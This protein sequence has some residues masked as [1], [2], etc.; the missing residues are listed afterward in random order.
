LTIRFLFL[1]LFPVVVLAQD[2]TTSPAKLVFVAGKTYTVSLQFNNCTNG[3]TTPPHD[4]TATNTK[5]SATGNGITVSTPAGPAHKCDWTGS[6]TLSQD[7]DT[8]VFAIVIQEEDKLTSIPFE[9]IAKAAGPIPPGLQPTVDVA[10]SVVP[11][12]IASDNFGGRITKLYY[13]IQVV[14]GNNSGYDLQLASI[15]FDLGSVLPDLNVPTDSYYMVRSS[16]QREQLVGVRNT[17]VNVIKAIGPILTGAAVFYTGTSLAGLHHKTHFLGITDI[18][19]NPFEKGV[20]AVF[21]DMTVQQ[22]INLDN[23]TLRDGLIIANNTQIRSIVFVNKDLLMQA[24]RSARKLGSSSKTVPKSGNSARPTPVDT[25][26]QIALINLDLAR[27]MEAIDKAEAASI[28]AAKHKEVEDKAAAKALADAAQVQG[29]ILLATTAAAAAETAAASKASTDKRA[30]VDAAAVQRKAV[31]DHASANQEQAAADA[32]AD[33]NLANQNAAIANRGDVETAQLVK[34]LGGENKI[35]KHEYNPQEVMR[36][37]GSLKLVGRSIQYLNRV[38]VISTPPGPGPQFTLSPASVKQDDAKITTLT[39]TLTGDGLTGGTLSASDSNLVLTNPSV[40]AGGKSFT[41][42][43]DASKAPPKVYSLTLTTSSASQ[44]A[45]FEVKPADIVVA[46]TNP[47][48]VTFA[49][50]SPPLAVTIT[51]NWLEHLSSVVPDPACPDSIIAYT[52]PDSSAAAIN[53]TTISIKISSPTAYPN[54][55]KATFKGSSGNTQAL[56]YTVQ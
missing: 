34:D 30:A 10:W 5:F 52:P 35:G 48:P 26:S 23:H 24:A 45:Q 20:E 41:A 36:Q 13:P 3:S 33:Q 4:L 2:Y 14:I 22:L 15:Q 56:A 16:L 12:R 9:V 54:G 18:F 21:P 1:C 31:T 53:L 38:S 42:S 50:G 51:G 40:G 46:S 49:H 39:L 19:S 55:C 25:R 17:T 44:S 43:L 29:A 11:R 6:V 28:A 8:G 37:L 27:K 47:T 7:A 32:I